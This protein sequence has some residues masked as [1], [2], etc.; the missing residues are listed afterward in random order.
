MAHLFIYLIR[1][2]ICLWLFNIINH[3]KTIIMS[4]LALFLPFVNLKQFT[5]H[6]WQINITHHFKMNIFLILPKSSPF[7]YMVD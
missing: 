6:I 4:F 2:F 1:V 5:C 3:F 7:A